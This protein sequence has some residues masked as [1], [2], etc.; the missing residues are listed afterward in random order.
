M[1]NLKINDYF[2]LGFLILISM[3]FL[4]LLRPFVIDI[5]L[6]VVL[7]IIF[8][9]PFAFVLKKTKSR[10]KA[11]SIMVALI[12][13][14]VTIPLFFV[15]LMVSFEATE[16]Y[17]I[18]REQLPKIQEMLTKE[19]LTE[20]AHRIPIAGEDIAAEIEKLNLEQVKE[21]STDILMSISTYTLK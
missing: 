2:F 21:V 4:T 5:F 9:K 19:S 7:F 3:A 13:L 16:N 11:A 14:T 10:K 17:R 8:R 18:V 15:G 1:K 6:A 20:L 12:T